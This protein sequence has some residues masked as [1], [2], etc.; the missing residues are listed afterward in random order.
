GL[1]RIVVLGQRCPFN[2]ADNGLPEDIFPTAE[3]RVCGMSAA[4]VRCEFELLTGQRFQR[5]PLHAYHSIRWG[6]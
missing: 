3:D 4:G 6:I 5:D 2:H 1:A